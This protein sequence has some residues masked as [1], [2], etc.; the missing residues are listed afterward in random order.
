MR[1]GLAA[2]AALLSLA[3][4]LVSLPRLPNA[5]PTQ[6]PTTLPRPTAVTPSAPSPQPQVL[7]PTPVVDW[8]DERRQG[9]ALLDAFAADAAN[10]PDATRYWIEA[11]VRFD[12]LQPQAVIDGRE[13]LRFTNPLEQSLE[14]LV[15]MLWPNDGQYAA[16]MQA[17][18]A[19]IDGQIV[20][21]E[22]EPQ[23]VGQRFRLPRPLP[24]GDALDLTIPFH[25]VAYGPMRPDAP[26]RFGIDEGMLLAP[27]FYPL[28]PRLTPEGDWQV[29][30]APPGG[31]TTNSDIA[32]YDVNLTVPEDLAAASTG[33]E[34]ERRAGGDGTLTV[35]F[36]SGPTRDFAF[37]LGRFVTAEAQAGEVVV[38]A[39]V[40][41]AHAAAAES[42]ARVAAQA[43]E[44][45]GE[46]IGPYPYDELDVVDAPGAFGGIEY[47]GLIFIGVVGDRGDDIVVVHEVAH[48]WFY[49]LIGNDQLL[50]PWLDEAAASYAETLYFEAIGDPRSA[51]GLLDEDRH[52]LRS[53][54]GTDTPIGLP[55][56]EYNTEAEYGVYVYIKGALFFEALRSRLGESGFRAFLK[57][58]FTQFRYGFAT[59]ESLRS[60]AEA[61]CACDLGE[62]FD[63]WVFKGGELPLP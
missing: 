16:E 41:E 29:L 49:G 54:R 42:T 63:L 3:C 33:R 44:A 56:S 57:N 15:L 55:V 13:R 22:P 50:E 45:F 9:E 47:P 5:S 52:I 21:P 61:T 11:S 8:G 48:Q 24:P 2:G 31:D 4:S 20:A 43:V 30:A 39:W 35:R 34:V 23:G 51:T 12:P 38:R 1:V 62:L 25:I 37:A 60:T 46:L 6:A 32:F 26:K 17:G 28:V 14:D 19:I 58:Y 40:L 36:A 59:G 10:L 18:P 27:T 53:M 7:P